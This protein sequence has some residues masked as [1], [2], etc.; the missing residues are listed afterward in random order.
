MLENIK[1]KKLKRE[2]P[3]LN[4]II[5]SKDKLNLDLKWFNS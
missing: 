4:N 1:R 5:Q 3:L 2:Q